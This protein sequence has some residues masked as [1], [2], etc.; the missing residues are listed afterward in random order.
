MSQGIVLLAAPVHP[1]L[2]EGLQEAGYLL[3]VEEDITQQKA[4][5]LLAD[6]VG[7][8]TSTRLQLDQELL[9]CAPHL[10]WI[11]RM[12]SGMEVIDVPYALSQGIACYSSPEGNSNAVGEH[13]LGMLLALT[14]KITWSHQQIQGGHWVRDANRGI[15]LEGKTIGV[16]GYGHT[17]RAFARKLAGFDVQVLAYD[18]YQTVAGNHYITGCAS[19]EPIWERADILSFHVPLQ[20]DTVH[21]FDA[22]F[23]D[24]MQRPFILINTSRGP[25]VPLNT[26]YAG[27]KS[28][29]IRGV[30]LDVLEEEPLEKMTPEKR[31]LVQE[32]SGFETVILTPHI[33]GY[34]HEALYK[35]SLSLRKKIVTPA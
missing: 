1:V 15:E 30:C 17:G 26:V 18:K 3:R 7:V 28:G 33:G 27:L 24:A 25:V 19:L 32:I 23:L 31:E 9:A 12:G 22:A 2:T 20:A 6:C 11:G 35:M 13:A 4:P 34:S 10:K 29:K 5:G 14:K 16:I 21:Y 8:I